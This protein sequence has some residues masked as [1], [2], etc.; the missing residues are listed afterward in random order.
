MAVQVLKRSQAVV[1]LPPRS[2][3]ERAFVNEPVILVAQ[4]GD[5]GRGGYQR[6]SLDSMPA[7][8]SVYLL[9]DGR[10]TNLL[11]PLVPVLPEGR[12]I[13]ALP[14]IVEEQLLQDALDDG[15]TDNITIIVGHAT[16]K[17]LPT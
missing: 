14:N 9:F 12:L 1:W 10:D 11:S 6:C 17:D 8:K 4:G 2:V 16:P 7:V 3:G 15:G 13:K 5:E